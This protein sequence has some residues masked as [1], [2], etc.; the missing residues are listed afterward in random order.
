MSIKHTLLACLFFMLAV[1]SAVQ[2]Q[3]AEAAAGNN[4]I[5]DLTAEVYKIPVEAPQVKLLTDRIKPEFDSVHLD[6]SFKKEITG[7]GEKFVVEPLKK[8]S[9]IDKADV[10]KMISRKR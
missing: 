5:I 9:E 10:G 7:A 6:K 3:Q 2:A 4:E 1:S 8:G